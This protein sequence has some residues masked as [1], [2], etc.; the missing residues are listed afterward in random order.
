MRTKICISCHTPKDIEEFHF[1]NKAKGTR[2]DKCITCAKEYAKKS[3]LD[4]R[5]K[6]LDQINTRAENLR[7]ANRKSFNDLL[8]KSK[9]SVCIEADSR[10][11]TAN[12]TADDIFYKTEAAFSLVLD[13]AVVVCL[14]C[15]AKG[16]HKF[17]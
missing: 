14:N 6:R 10:C 1:R 3:Y 11:L 5:D 9:C 15:Q 8:A 7:A 13:K 2:Q 16:L 17:S 4:N 12:V